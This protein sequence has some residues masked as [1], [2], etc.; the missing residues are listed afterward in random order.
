MVRRI[1]RRKFL[2]YGSASLGTSIFLKAC[3]SN[4]PTTT[5]ESPTT[6][7]SPVAAA[8][9]SSG[10]TIKVGILHSLSGTMAI[11]EKSVVDAEMLAIEADLRRES[12]KTHRPR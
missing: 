2:I 6:A 1:G 12:E 7:S 10:N 4:Q 5:A 9:G 3:A 8:G 11:S